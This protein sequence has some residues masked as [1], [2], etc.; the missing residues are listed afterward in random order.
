VEENR[1]TAR[2]DVYWQKATRL[3]NFVSTTDNWNKILKLGECALSIGVRVTGYE[4]WA[5][6]AEFSKN[7]RVVLLPSRCCKK[8]IQTRNG[9]SRPMGG[10]A[11]GSLR[12][13]Y[14]LLGVGYGLSFLRYASRRNWM[15]GSYASQIQGVQFWEG[16]ATGVVGVASGSIGM[17]QAK[18]L[19][20]KANQQTRKRLEVNFWISLYATGQSLVG[21]GQDL[22]SV[23][24]S[25]PRD[26]NLVLS[27]TSAILSFMKGW[28]ATPTPPPRT[29]K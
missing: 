25:V 3:S 21:L 9:V 20:Q 18:T 8:L 1:P 4:T 28:V 6:I 7:G 10:W 17:I 13:T 5:E 16:L 19:E 14:F 29:H 12:A 27:S 11:D 23:L 26:L 15:L 22:L 2:S 24:G